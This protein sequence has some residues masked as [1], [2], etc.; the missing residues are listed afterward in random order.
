MAYKTLL[1]FDR[2]LMSRALVLYFENIVVYCGYVIDILICVRTFET[3]LDIV[4]QRYMI[5]VIAIQ[6][7]RNK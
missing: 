5:Q 7:G 3:M 1:Y 2:N 4:C 6:R